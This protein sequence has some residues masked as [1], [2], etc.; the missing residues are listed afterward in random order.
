MNALVQE[1]NANGPGAL[2]Y[3]QFVTNIGGQWPN[4]PGTLIQ[5]PAAGGGA[6]V[7][8]AIRRQNFGSNGYNSILEIRDGAGTRLLVPVT[9][10][11]IWRAWSSAG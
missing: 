4:L 1:I 5:S 3:Y 9:S 6:R 2:S 11:R 8:L 10:Q 7:R